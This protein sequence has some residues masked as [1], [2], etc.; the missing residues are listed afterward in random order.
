MIIF[1]KIFIVTLFVICL[2]LLILNII[3]SRAEQKR[4]KRVD[5]SRVYMNTSSLMKDTTSPSKFPPILHYDE[6]EFKKGG[7]NNDR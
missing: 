4:N 2:V 7:K 3:Y 1:A 6:A 5:S